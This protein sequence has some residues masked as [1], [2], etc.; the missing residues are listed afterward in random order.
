MQQAFRS[1]LDQYVYVATDYTIPTDGE[2]TKVF[3]CNAYIDDQKL[4]DAIT[5]IDKMKTTSFEYKTESIYYL[6]DNQ[7]MKELTVAYGD[8][9]VATVKKGWLG[10]IN[11]QW[12]VTTYISP[13]QSSED[14]PP[15]Y[16]TVGCYVIPEAY[17]PALEMHF[18]E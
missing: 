18:F 17:W 14:S 8:C 3:W 16:Y 11:G 9:P 10:K 1:F 15:L 2:I 7:R 4:M 13:A 12:V 6:D 5:A